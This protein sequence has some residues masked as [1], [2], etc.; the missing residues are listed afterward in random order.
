MRKELSR[1]RANNI[2]Y[3]HM[4]TLNVV[5]SDACTYDVYMSTS[6]SRYGHD[7]DM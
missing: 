5:R 4:Y 7:H 3:T 2:R 6:T 1:K